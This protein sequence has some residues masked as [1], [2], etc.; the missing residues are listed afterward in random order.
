MILQKRETGKRKI[1]FHESGKGKILLFINKPQFNYIILLI[2]SK[3][4][5]YTH[6]QLEDS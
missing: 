5:N 2:N 6:D 3:D 1:R 4:K